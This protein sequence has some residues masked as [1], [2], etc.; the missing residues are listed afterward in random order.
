MWEGQD[1]RRVAVLIRN[2]M[3]APTAP[4]DVG[5]EKTGR[6]RLGGLRV[7]DPNVQEHGPAHGHR[8]PI[9]SDFNAR[10]QG[11]R[12]RQIGSNQ[13]HAKN[14]CAPADYQTLQSV[15][16]RK[17]SVHVTNVIRQGPLS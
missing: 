13:R 1:D 6:K 9:G 17:N 2:L 8:F 12:V 11:L 7:G 16:P 14:D 5:E 10:G 3:R 4:V 15:V